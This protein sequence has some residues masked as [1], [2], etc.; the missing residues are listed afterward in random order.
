M[1][2]LKLAYEPFS[3]THARLLN[4][5]IEHGGDRKNDDEYPTPE[6]AIL[7]QRVPTLVPDILINDSY[8]EAYEWEMPHVQAERDQ[9][10][11]T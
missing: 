11:P 7:H 1:L 4:P 3:Q 10:D 9:R 6:G 5:T 8:K 2:S